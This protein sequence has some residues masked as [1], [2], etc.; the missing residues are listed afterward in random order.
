V[1]RALHSCRDY[2]RDPEALG[3]WI[4]MLPCIVLVVL[5]WVLPPDRQA[6]LVDILVLC[7]QLVAL[8]LT[9]LEYTFRW[10]VL[11]AGGLAVILI[12]HTVLQQFERPWR[13]EAS[14]DDRGGEPTDPR[15]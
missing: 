7:L 8:A 11:V 5:L 3:G 14:D 1:K 10:L 6:R 2:F 4:V 12:G 13:H 9:W 15:L